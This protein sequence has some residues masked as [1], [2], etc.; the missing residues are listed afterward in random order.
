MSANSQLPESLKKHSDYFISR[1]VTILQAPN[2]VLFLPSSRRDALQLPIEKDMLVS[3]DTLFHDLLNNE[4]AIPHLIGFYE[5]PFRHPIATFP[6]LPFIIR[7]ASLMLE[8]RDGLHGFNGTVHGGL[9][10][11]VMDEAMGS[12]LAQ[13]DILNRQA[14]AK[15]I[16]PSDS[17]KFTAA[18]TARMDVKY[19]RPIPTPQVVVATVSLDRIEGRKIYMHVVV[20]D[21]GNKECASCDGVFISIP[22]GKL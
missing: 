22:N 16:I 13:N 9:T 1:G 12:L 18:V 11:A 21:E 6:H 19:R 8:L 10:C 3:Q 17:K 20:K 15:G 7:S 2:I 4:S 14:R 5:D